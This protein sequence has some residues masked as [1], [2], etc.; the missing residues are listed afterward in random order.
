M[1]TVALIPTKLLQLKSDGK[2]N[3]AVQNIRL[4]SRKTNRKSYVAYWMAP[5]LVTLNDL[6]GHSPVAGLFTCNASNICAVLYQ[7]STDS[8]LARSLSDSWASCSQSTGHTHKPTDRQ[9]NRWLE[10]KT[11]NYRPLSLY[12]ERRALIITNYLQWTLLKLTAVGL[13]TIG[14]NVHCVSEKIMPTFFIWL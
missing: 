10:K 7:I 6:E 8:V 3:K 14:L 13:C 12:R 1:W 2:G 4:H 9:T 5:V 11:C